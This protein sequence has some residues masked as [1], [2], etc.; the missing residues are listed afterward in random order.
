[1]TLPVC[2]G[3]CLPAIERLQGRGRTT[4]LPRNIDSVSGAGTRAQH[5]PFRRD[6]AE[7]DNICRD[8]LGPR[9]VSSSQG[10]MESARKPKQAMEE[11][12]RPLLRK[13]RGHSER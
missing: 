11:L 12:I 6:A 1:M 10:D 3:N 7:D 9:R 8:F 2:G 4:Q 13:V 5:R